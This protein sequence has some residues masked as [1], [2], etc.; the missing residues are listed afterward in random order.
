MLSNKFTCDSILTKW[1]YYRTDP[2]AIIFVGVWRIPDDSPEY[3]FELIGKN[4]LTGN[5]TGAH[6][7]QVP[8]NEIIQAKAGD[9]I[10]IHYAG[11]SETGGI[12]MTIKDNAK[13]ATETGTSDNLMFYETF[14]AGVFDENMIV[15]VMNF[16][17]ND[18]KIQNSS[19]GL[20]GHLI[21]LSGT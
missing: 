10:G 17:T 9:F 6:V 4:Q 3:Y 16:D 20:K 21:P 8:P 18:K 2:K 15:G 19:I 7:V 12:G 14:S 13:N 1:E 5:T 11:R